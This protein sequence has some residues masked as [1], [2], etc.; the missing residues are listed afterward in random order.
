MTTTKHNHLEVG[1]TRGSRLAITLERVKIEEI[2]TS[3]VWDST[4]VVRWLP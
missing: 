2:I 3:F 1:N 4:N